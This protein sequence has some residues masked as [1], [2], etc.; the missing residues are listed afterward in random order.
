MLEH[1]LAFRAIK[2]VIHLPFEKAIGIQLFKT[3]HDLFREKLGLLKGT[4]RYLLVRI[5]L[6][7]YLLLEILMLDPGPHLVCMSYHFRKKK[8]Q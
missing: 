6:S 3:N 7:H 2:K 8:K 1:A 4:F 5:F